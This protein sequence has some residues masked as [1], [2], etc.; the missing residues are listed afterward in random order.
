MITRYFKIQFLTE[1]YSETSCLFLSQFVVILFRQIPL[2]ENIPLTTASP[3]QPGILIENDQLTEVQ[4][5]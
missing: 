5:K 1:N 4:N 3:Q 2:T